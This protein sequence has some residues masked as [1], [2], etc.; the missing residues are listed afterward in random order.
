MELCKECQKR[1]RVKGRTQCS[2][3]RIQK[4]R[5]DNPMMAAYINLRCNAKR[6][7]HGFSLTFD[8]FTEFAI[9]TEYIIKK[10]KSKDS[11]TIDRIDNKKGYSLDNIQVLTNFDNVKKQ[12]KTMKLEYE[13]ETKEFWVRDITPLSMDNTF[14]PF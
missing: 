13:W 14:S 9:E 2:T 1:K 8:E 12:H 7:G 3:C 4:Y 6:R 5:K 10:G 11:Y